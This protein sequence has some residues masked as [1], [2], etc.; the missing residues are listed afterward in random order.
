[1]WFHSHNVHNV[2]NGAAKLFWLR[3][4]ERTPAHLVMGERARVPV[5][6]HN[7]AMVL[8]C[9]EVLLSTHSQAGC[10]NGDCLIMK[11][12]MDQIAF[13]MNDVW[14]CRLV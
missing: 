2:C 11:V 9:Q 4:S 14:N 3:V 10:N 8:V 1:M 6:L 13:I 12:I 7:K 5:T